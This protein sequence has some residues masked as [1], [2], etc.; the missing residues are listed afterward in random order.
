MY[1]WQPS[2]ERIGPDDF[3]NLRR[4]NCAAIA[5]SAIDK[6]SPIMNFLLIKAFEVAEASA[7]QPFAFFHF[8]FASLI[9]IIVFSEQLTY[10]ILLGSIIVVGSGVF[11][12]SREKKGEF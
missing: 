4:D 7:I 11:Y 8:V 1:S 10:S 5:I 2:P 6:L 3:G 9:G 12:Y